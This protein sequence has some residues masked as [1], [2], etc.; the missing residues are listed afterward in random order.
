[1]ATG[2]SRAMCPLIRKGKR[3]P[4]ARHWEP[5]RGCADEVA[6]ARG[7]SLSVVERYGVRSAAGRRTTADRL[8]S[9]GSSQSCRHRSA[10][11]QRSSR[12]MSGHNAGQACLPNS[13]GVSWSGLSATNREGGGDEST[14]IPLVCRHGELPDTGYGAGVRATRH[15]GRSSTSGRHLGE[16][17]TRVRFRRR[18]SSPS[19]VA[20]SR[21]TVETCI[22]SREVWFTSG[23][24]RPYRLGDQTQL[25]LPQRSRHPQRARDYQRRD[26]LTHAGRQVRVPG[27]PARDHERQSEHR[28]DCRRRSGD[29]RRQKLHRHNRRLVRR[30]C[31]R[32][33]QS[34]EWG[35]SDHSDRA[36]PKWGWQPIRC[37][38]DHTARHQRDRSG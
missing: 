9:G 17:G 37:D 33:V 20:T 36:A 16:P 26:E 19:A 6:S 3:V 32:L 24:Q 14:R 2:L 8:S 35:H 18:P 5:L 21:S 1:M 31:C 15:G 28:F 11:C 25:S 30:P 29:H 4:H 27:G 22:A 7:R 12:A 38:R 10:R 13:R 34:I 23:D